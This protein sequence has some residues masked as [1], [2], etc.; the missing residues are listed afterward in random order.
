[1]LAEAIDAVIGI[2]TQRDSHEVGGCSQADGRSWRWGG[3]AGRATLRAILGLAPTNDECAGRSV[4][5]L[6]PGARRK[7]GR[8]VA[9][10]G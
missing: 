1:M 5:G 8:L 3:L 2:D 4:V 6:R 7:P 9:T 10:L